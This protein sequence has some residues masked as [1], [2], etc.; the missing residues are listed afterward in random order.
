MPTYQELRSTYA[1]MAIPELR[2]LALRPL[3][4]TD[5]AQAALAD[6]LALRDVLTEYEI[7]PSLMRTSTR[8]VSWQEWWLTAFQAWVTFQIIGFGSV[9]AALDP[10][11]DGWTL[12]ASAI[13]AVQCFGLVLIANKHPSTRRFWLGLLAVLL[14][15]RLTSAPILGLLNWGMLIGIAIHV[16]WY[17]YW[18]ESRH[19]A[20]EF[21]LVNQAASPA[22]A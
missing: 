1:L 17:R 13:M 2:H 11:L 20:T 8:A 5:Q 6:E 14:V 7:P 15:V 4:L 10:I 19:V 12:L 22:D 21:G 3:E 9:V 18:L 16:A